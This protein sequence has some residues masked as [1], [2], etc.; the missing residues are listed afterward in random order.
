MLLAGETIFAAGPSEVPDTASHNPASDAWLWAV[1][2]T[3]GTKKAQYK[4][5]AQPVFDSMAAADGRL[6]F[7]TVDG[8][9]V[10]YQAGN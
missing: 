3:D 5:K 7:A 6:F 9:V 2:A 4:L 10:C 1:S 8:R